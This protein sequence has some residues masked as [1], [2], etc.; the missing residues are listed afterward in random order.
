LTWPALALVYF[1]LSTPDF[2][3]DHGVTPRPWSSA[4]GI[5]SPS[6]VRSKSEYSSCK[7]MSGTQPRNFAIIWASMAFQAGVSEKPI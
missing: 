1:P 2:S 4:I 3:G 6:M 7:A 5:N